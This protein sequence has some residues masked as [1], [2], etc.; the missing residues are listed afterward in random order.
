MANHVP[1][2]K[3]TF[4]IR[5]LAAQANGRERLPQNVGCEEA[6]DVSVIL[7]EALNRLPKPGQA[8]K[9]SPLLGGRSRIHQNGETLQFKL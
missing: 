4:G 2:N 6:T 8:R 1:R 9:T 5:N 7:A 3:R